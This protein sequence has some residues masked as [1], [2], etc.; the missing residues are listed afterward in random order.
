MDAKRMDR[1]LR[2]VDEAVNST[3]GYTHAQAL[4]VEETVNGLA[5]GYAEEVM[6]GE[7]EDKAAPSMLIHSCESMLGIL[8]LRP[9]MT[10]GEYASAIVRWHIDQ[11]KEER[12][13]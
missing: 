5:R 10:A 6:A 1:V 12:H 7:H 11:I 2:R 4:A 3:V 13:G 9:R 8:G